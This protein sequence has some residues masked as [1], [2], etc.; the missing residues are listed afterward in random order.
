MSAI[1]LR[2][3]SQNHKWLNYCFFKRLLPAAENYC[4][5]R[6]QSCDNFS[7]SKSACPWFCLYL[8][9]LKDVSIHFLSLVPALVCTSGWNSS[10]RKIPPNVFFKIILIL[11]GL[12]QLSELAYS[13]VIQE[14]VLAHQKLQDHCLLCFMLFNNLSWKSGGFPQGLGRSQV[15]ATQNKNN[16]L[17]PL[18]TV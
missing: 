4:P 7:Q 8:Q 1:N 16:Q 15:L 3:W 17:E 18:N 6:G 2:L 14:A 5:Q 10:E 9:L 12:V 13:P 11:K